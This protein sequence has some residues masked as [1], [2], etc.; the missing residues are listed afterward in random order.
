MRPFFKVFFSYMC[1]YK[2]KGDIILHF[3]ANKTMQ[4]IIFI[5]K[6]I[7]TRAS[8]RGASTPIGHRGWGASLKIVF[9]FIF[10][11]FDPHFMER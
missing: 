10:V 2:A 5:K 7:L 11:N 6:K 9:K 4:G 3:G 1:N 8:K